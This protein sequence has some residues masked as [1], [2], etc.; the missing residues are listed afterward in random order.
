V[1]SNLD[2]IFGIKDID[3]LPRRIFLDTNIVQY[4]FDFGEFIFDN[5]SENESYLESPKGKQLHSDTFLFQQ[6]LALQEIFIPTTRL[7]YYFV[8]SK[9]ICDEIQKT[10]DYLNW[11]SDLWQYWQTTISEYEGNAFT[12]KGEEI[13]NQLQRDNS[14]KNILSQ[15]DLKIVC[16]AVR[17]ECDA[18]L[19][20]DRFR[21]NQVQIH[22]KYGILVMSPSDFYTLMKDFKPL[23]C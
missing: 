8:V 10:S 18:I 9:S 15:A 23:W 2:L 12:G 19:T 11:F 20:C 4:L 22:Q 16:D 5:Y 3:K 13:A 14:M 21:K 1:G 7:P 6:I 17:L